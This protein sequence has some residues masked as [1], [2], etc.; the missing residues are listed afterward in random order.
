MPA[1]VGIRDGRGYG[2]FGNGYHVDASGRALPLGPDG[3]ILSAEHDFRPNQDG[4]YIGASVWETG[5]FDQLLKDQGAIWAQL[6]A[7]NPARQ[8]FYNGDDWTGL[9]DGWHRYAQRYTP[10]QTVIDNVLHVLSFA[11]YP[12]ART[13][14]M[15]ESSFIFPNPGVTVTPITIGATT[16]PDLDSLSEDELEQRYNA[17]LISDEEM[18]EQTKYRLSPRAL[19]TIDAIGY[20]LAKLLNGMPASEA[21]GRL[22]IGGDSTS[23]LWDADEIKYYRDMAMDFAAGMRVTAKKGTPDRFFFVSQVERGGGGQPLDTLAEMYK[24]FGDATGNPAS[25]EYVAMFDAADPA[26]PKPIGESFSD[27]GPTSRRPARQVATEVRGDLDTTALKQLAHQTIV[28]ARAN[29]GKTGI[30]WDQPMSVEAGWDGSITQNAFAFGAMTREY[31]RIDKNIERGKTAY[32]LIMT[33]S[34]DVIYEREGI[35]SS[36]G[37]M[38][39]GFGR[40]RRAAAQ[41]GGVINAESHVEASAIAK[42]GDRMDTL[43]G[44]FTS[45]LGCFPDASGALHTLFSNV[46][47]PFY[48]RWRT[49]QANNQYWNRN[50]ARDWTAEMERIRDK[51]I[52]LTP[53]MSDAFV[54][55]GGGGGHHHHG[56]GGRG[57]GRRY[58]GGG[59]GGWYGDWGYPYPYP[60]PV[61]VATTEDLV[62]DP[63]RG[64]IPRTLVRGEKALQMSNEQ[65]LVPQAMGRGRARANANASAG[66]GSLIDLLKILSPGSAGVN[67]S[68]QVDSQNV[69]HVSICV[70]GRCYERSLDISA[71]IDGVLDR[72]AKHHAALHI[73]AGAPLPSSPPPQVA[74]DV[75]TATD[76]IVKG[77]QD[78]ICGALLDE[79]ASVISA[80]WWHSLTSAVH[81]VGHSAYQAGK[82]VAHTLKA[83]KVPIEVAATAAAV[84]F[85]GPQAGPVAGQLTGSLIDAANGDANAQQVVAQAQQ[86]AQNNPQVAQALGAAQQAV[87]QTTAAYHVVQ[88]HVDAANGVVD[89]IKQVK[90]LNSA[91]AAGDAAAQQAQQLVQA[92]S[93]CAQA[94]GGCG[95]AA[96]QAACAAPADAVSSG[97]RGSW[98]DQRLTPAEIAK[99]RMKGTKLV[100]PLAIQEVKEEK[101]PGTP[102]TAKKYFSVALY[103]SADG[104]LSGDGGGGL[105]VTAAY[106]SLDKADDWY[107]IAVEDAAGEGGPKSEWDDASYLAIYDTT[108]PTWPSP[109][110][111]TARRRSF[112]GAP[113]TRSSGQRDIVGMIPLMPWLVLAAAGAGLGGYAWYAHEQKKKAKK[114]AKQIA[115]QNAP[116]APGDEGRSASFPMRTAESR[117][118]DGRGQAIESS[119]PELMPGASAHFSPEAINNARSQYDMSVRD[120]FDHPDIDPAG[121]PQAV[122]SG[123]VSPMLVDGRR[124]AISHVKSYLGNL[125]I[126]EP[127]GTAYGYVHTAHDKTGGDPRFG[128]ISFASV[129]EADDWYGALHPADFLY[130]AYFDPSDPTFPMPLH[131]EL[132]EGPATISGAIWPLLAIAAVAAGGA[133]A[134]AWNRHAEEK[135]NEAEAAKVAEVMN[136]LNEEIMSLPRAPVASSGEGW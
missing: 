83:L 31:N 30:D 56:G 32:G 132:G 76:N 91:A 4:T 45:A 60:Y 97:L 118:Y 39:A 2:P 110:E 135:R 68:A 41:V 134:Y 136:K 69:L 119:F 21:L 107:G 73:E 113:P 115:A 57:R 127:A 126:R 90:D 1:G 23:K 43:Q 24:W 11:V 95:V 105:V 81:S 109:V 101:S 94:N 26:W 80:G 62:Y 17:G 116:Y 129:D 44:Q 53:A 20:G 89:A 112:R 48:T 18:L 65:A 104:D 114:L 47:I 8:K 123:E 42:L 12:A 50:E 40:G 131:E 19:E 74:L 122:T 106:D 66:G 117:A 120:R 9:L 54:S 59:G 3:Q 86:L 35:P 108:D 70:D 125:S 67:V 77:A 93:Q 121:G 72:I 88:T 5:E 64:W 52:D 37:E 128:V 99:M 79:H 98:S 34:G 102:Y 7:G 103:P 51:A 55:G 28:Q 133:G 29:H 14:G 15:P 71:T 58:Y 111:E 13:A 78:M 33:P 82:G 63:Q 36:S 22:Q 75:Q 16:R 85:V 25:Y 92:V 87:A 100:L 10:S 38:V 49:W 124:A 46:W 130:A 96:D 27:L 84:A 61:P 6:C